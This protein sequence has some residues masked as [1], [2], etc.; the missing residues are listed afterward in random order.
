ME[1]CN[2][3]FGLK[4]FFDLR[5]GEAVVLHLLDPLNTFYGFD[6]LVSARQIFFL[7]LEG[8]HAFLGV[9][10]QGAVSCACQPD[11]FPDGDIFRGLYYIQ[12]SLS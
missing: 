3:L 4:G 7:L 5:N 11:Q 6:S 12:L 10:F 1:P 2:P 9:V 8:Q